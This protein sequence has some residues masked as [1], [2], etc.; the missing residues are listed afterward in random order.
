MQGKGAS[1]FYDQKIK[2]CKHSE[3]VLYKNYAEEAGRS[4]TILGSIV[5]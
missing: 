5:K 1:D 4:L 2:F 3:E